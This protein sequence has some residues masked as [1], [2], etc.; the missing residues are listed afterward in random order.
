MSERPLEGRVALVTGASRG[1]GYAAALGLASAGAHV[2][3]LAR[4]TGGLE[5]LDDAIRAGAGHATLVPMNMKD[6]DGLD[7]LGAALHE[8][9]GKLDILVGNAA[10]LG[11]VTPLGHLKPNVFDDVMAIN[12][13][14]NYRLIRA[15]DPLL[16]AAPAGRAVFMTSPLAHAPK[17][18]TGP[19]GASKAALEALVRS[20]AA[21]HAKSSVRANIL[22]PGITAT[23]LRGRLMPGETPSNLRKP[24][25]VVPAVLRLTGDD[26]EH[27]GALYSAETANWV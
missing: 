4:T 10:I 19:Y 20:Y 5:E 23:K 16:Q 3:A 9:H 2:I 8:R 25:D 6:G 24:A 26:C 1:I 7:R 17:A 15:M 13:T 18:Y 11:T 14:G 12:V 22:D 21:E 27:N